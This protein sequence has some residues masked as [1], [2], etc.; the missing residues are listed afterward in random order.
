LYDNEPLLLAMARINPHAFTMVAIEHGKALTTLIEKS[1]NMKF[2]KKLIMLT[3]SNEK[4]RALS[5][6]LCA[7][8]IFEKEEIVEFCLEQNIGF[9]EQ[10][11][12]AEG[13]TA[14][15][16]C[17]SQET[18][19]EIR[20]ML[21][22]NQDLQS[23]Q[24]C[25]LDQITPFM[26]AL[27][28]FPLEEIRHLCNDA[29]AHANGKSTLLFAAKNRDPYAAVEF[30]LKRGA[31]MHLQEDESQCGWT[32]FHA[33]CLFNSEIVKLMIKHKAKVNIR[34]DAGVTPLIGCCRL[35]EDEIVDDICQVLIKYGFQH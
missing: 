2:L 14:L 23:L 22:A 13:K 1:N 28:D 8:I 21:L 31:D 11:I 3:T 19:Q 27:P 16:L 26:H 7:A 35:A 20:N 10:L 25:D 34:D 30:L 29:D 9:E 12:E 15:H 5:P 33:F 4:D 24:I 17:F 32:A 6:A 18:P